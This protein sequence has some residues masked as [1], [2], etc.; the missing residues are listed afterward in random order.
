MF[1][2]AFDL[3]MTYRHDSDIV[4]GNRYKR[5]NGSQKEDFLKEISLAKIESYYFVK[6][7]TLYGITDLEKRS[8][9]IAWLVS[10]CNTPSKREKY[11]EEM[12]KNEELKIHIFGKCS[13][14]NSDDILNLPSRQDNYEL[15]Y[16]ILAEQYKFY[17][18]FENAKCFSYITEKFFLALNSGM[19]PIHIATE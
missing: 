15:G 19:L 8:K 7:L 16:D 10:H 9:D 18:S 5:K 2:G 6:N 17:L 4:I 11:V 12:K 3:T 1:Q 13:G 14:E